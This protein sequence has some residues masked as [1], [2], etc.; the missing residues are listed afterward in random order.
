[1]KHILAYISGLAFLVGLTGCVTFND[2]SS[3]ASE[4]EDINILRED[5]NRVQGRVETVELENRRMVNEV[6][7]LRADSSNT[8]N[9]AAIQ[10]RL[11]NLERQIQA[12]N[13]SREKDKQAIVD[14]LSAK[15]AEI[16][17]KGSGQS[18][19]GGAG[20]EYI[21]KPGETLSAIAAAYKVK[22]GAILEANDLKDPDNLRAGQKLVIPR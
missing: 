4:Q 9:E 6:E 3:I 21:V 7:K 20:N 13:A 2:S 12:V 8:R 22:V 10:E 5:L 11:D 19:R 1:M 14:Q 17:S 15:I 16:M 18:S